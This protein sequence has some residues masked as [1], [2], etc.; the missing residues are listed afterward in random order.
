LESA[1]FRSTTKDENGRR[2]VLRKA[3]FSEFVDTVHRI[4]AQAGVVILDAW[5]DPDA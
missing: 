1:P 2:D 4:A 3:P 5:S